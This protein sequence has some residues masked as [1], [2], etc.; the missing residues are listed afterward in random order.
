RIAIGI[1]VPCRPRLLIADEPTTALDVTVQ[2][3]I[4]RLLA[5]LRRENN[6]AVILIT[7]ALGVMSSIADRVSIFYAGR[8]VE[9]GQ[10]AQVIQRPRHPYTRSLLDALPHPEASQDKPLVAIGGSPPTPG[11]FPPGCAFHPR[12]GFL[13]ESCRHDVPELVDVGDRLL[14]CPVDPFVRGARPSCRPASSPRRGGAAPAG[15]RA[16]ARASPSTPVRSSASSASRAAASRRSRGRRSGWCRSRAAP[17][18]S[19]TTR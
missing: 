8:V 9:S 5:R 6:L 7:H 11:A 15:A 19:R 16:R 2:A 18:A 12:C 17:C 1:A 13:R 3:G 14:P 10:T 4:L